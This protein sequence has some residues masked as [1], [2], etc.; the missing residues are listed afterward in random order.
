MPG[1]AC[2]AGSKASSSAKSACPKTFPSKLAIAAWAEAA[3]GA[4]LPLADQ[5]ARRARTPQELA[6][7][8]LR[9]LR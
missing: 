9:T 8:S 7:R 2:A 1:W 6:M 5:W 3:Q 4:G